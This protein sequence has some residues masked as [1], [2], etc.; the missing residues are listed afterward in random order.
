MSNKCY[1]TDL[2]QLYTVLCTLI[3][4]VTGRK[5]WRKLG[6]QA[7]PRGPYATIY[8]SEGPSPTQ[9]VVEEEPLME[10]G[11]PN[12]SIREVPVGLTRLECEAEFR[13]NVAK[14][15][16]L[17]A[18][19]RFRQSLQLSARFNDLWR[20]S[21][22]VGEIRIIDISAMFRADVEGRAAVRFNLYVD[23]GATPLSTEHLIYEI[24]HCQIRVYPEQ[25]DEPVTPP[26]YTTIN[27]PEKK[28]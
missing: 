4:S 27:A 24:E 14:A 17:D 8:V 13:R 7:A 5:C 6:L 11:A 16:A 15:S 28:P 3:T 25:T 10:I 19:V 20:I 18:A 1:K 21:G 26:P 9:D 12:P 22:L 2:D 23:L